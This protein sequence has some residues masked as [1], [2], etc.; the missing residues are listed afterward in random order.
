MVAGWNVNRC[1]LC[2]SDRPADELREFHTRDFRGQ[3]IVV[4][5]CVSPTLCVAAA[6]G[7]GTGGLRGTW[8]PT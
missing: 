5:I 7:R 2:G 4:L 1:V 3:Q 6:L 8:R